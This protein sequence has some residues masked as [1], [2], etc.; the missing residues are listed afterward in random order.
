MKNNNVIFFVI[1]SLG[2]NLQAISFCQWWHK[3]KTFVKKYPATTIAV[4]SAP[5]AVMYFY[6]GIKA[7]NERIELEKMVPGFDRLRA[8]LERD[9]AAMNRGHGPLY[10]INW[11]K[12]YDTIVRRKSPE[13]ADKLLSAHSREGLLIPAISTSFLA[14][15]YG[16]VS[17]EEWKDAAD[18][19]EAA[20]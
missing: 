18:K 8:G 11:G 17:Y 1:L 4:V 6:Y 14:M 12:V 7:K 10:R 20:E 13:L 19:L 3:T 9:C 16:C 2:V 5:I 15:F